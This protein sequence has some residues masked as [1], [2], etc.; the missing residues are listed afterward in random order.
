M[1]SQLVNLLVSTVSAA[2]KPALPAPAKSAERNDDQ[3]AR[4]LD[5]PPASPKRDEAP[6]AKDNTASADNKPANTDAGAKSASDANAK[7]ANDATET[8]AAAPAETAKDDETSEGTGTTSLAD[9]LLAALAAL[10]LNGEATKGKGEG[11]LAD[12]AALKDIKDAIGELSQMLG[13][14]VATLMQQLAALA[15]NVAAEGGGEVELAAKLNGWLGERLGAAGVTLDANVEASLAKLMNGLGDFAKAIPA[16]PKLA[17]AQLKLPEPVLAAKMAVTEPKLEIAEPELKV[18]PQSLERKAEAKPVEPGD[19]GQNKAPVQQ[20]A[21][22]NGPQD[23]TLN[24]TPTAAAAAQADTPPQID[25]ATTP[26]VVQTGYQTSQQQLNLPQIAFELS[27]QVGDGNTRFQIRLD[28]AELGRI[29]VKLDIDKNGQVHA[30]LTVEKAETLDLMQRDQRALEKALQQ[31]GLDQNK[32]NL[33]FSLKQNPFA[34]DQNQRQG[35]ERSGS[36]SGQDSQE[37]TEVSAPAITLYRGALQA[38]GLN[39]LA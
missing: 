11:D 26:R 20:A 8:A 15:K 14:D 38:S 6:A 18:E 25:A 16:E 4:L 35:E 10:G 30:R 1:A 32:T 2:V 28:P 3:F 5:S 37:E 23:N 31:A 22:Q 7:P 36:G 21:R 24:L 9:A 33:E 13:V 34:G 39:I 17:S 12:P 29:D 19:A 27:R